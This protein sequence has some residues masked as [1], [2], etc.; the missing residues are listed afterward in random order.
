MSLSLMLAVDEDRDALAV[1]ESQLARRYARDYRVEC[2]AD[3]A[4]ALRLLTE[5]AHDGKEVALVLARN[6]PA[7]TT[8]IELLDHVRRLHPHAKRALLVPS[9]S[10][11]DETTAEAIRV[12]LALGRIDY[13]VP[14]PAASLDE[15]FHEAVTSF[16]LEWARDRGLAPQTVHIVG[17]TWSG[18]A[19][20]LRKT[21]EQCA[22]PHTFCLADSDPGRKLLAVAGADPKLPLM[23]LPDGRVMN[24]PSNVE[25]AR[26]AGAPAGLAEHAFDAIIVGSGPAGLSAAVYGASEGLKILV[27]DEGG[28]GG[29]ARSSS[30]IRNY[31]GFAKGVSGSRLAEQAYRQAAAFGASFL[32]MHRAVALARSG[33]RLSVSIADGTQVGVGAVILATGATYRRLDVPSLEALHGAGVF[34]GSPLSEATALSGKDAYIAGGG[35]SAGQAALH[36]ARYARRVTL[37]VRAPSLEAGMSHYLVRAVEA[38]PNVR[39]RPGTEVVG[40]GGEG[41]L[42]QLVLR[43]RTTEEEETVAA[44]ALFV[45]IGAR[46]HSDWLPADIARDTHGFLLTGPDIPDGY[47]WPLERAPLALETSM[48]GVLAVGD[49]RHGSVKRVASAV[50]EGAI[51]VQL[52]HSIVD[53]LAQRRV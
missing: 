40:G 38:T 41:R 23:V 50:G 19:Y 2:L 43:E 47:D 15:E 3:P 16:L 34:Y 32:F 26:A 35:N 25:I 46:P 18:R 27:V 52:L 33:H 44:D 14:S 11:S 28:I 31:L 7:H 30:L 39:V 29:Q 13:Y 9:D 20:E 10:W 51:A 36:L 24:D 48:P 8:G 22:V 5:L 49:V 17:E 53:E 42:Q 12:S 6:P 4:Q 45:M 1:V 37:V 21:F